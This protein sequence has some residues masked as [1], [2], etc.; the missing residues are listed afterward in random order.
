MPPGLYT[1]TYI[2]P[3][4]DLLIR[5]CDPTRD[6][7]RVAEL[8]NLFE[9]EKVTAERMRQLD[10]ERQPGDFFDRLV[11][12]LDGKIVATGWASR[13]LWYARGLYRVALL[14]D[15]ECHRLGYG[16]QLLAHLERAAIED[17]ATSLEASASDSDSGVGLAFLRRH[18]YEVVAHSFESTLDLSTFDPDRH[19]NAVPLQGLRFFSFAETPMDEDAKRRLWDLNTETS[20]DEPHNDRE[21]RPTFEQFEA[22]IIGAS[23]FDPHGQF[24][25]A[26]GDEW[27]AMSAVGEVY[28]GSLYNLFT[29]V[30]RAYCGRGIAKAV[31]VMATTFA[32]S[33]G[34]AYLRTNND[35][36]NAPML[37]IN[38]ALGYTSEPGKYQ[39]RKIVR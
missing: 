8:R 1:R 11:A 4:S 33:S 7:D 38:A 15:P 24:I 28:E 10:E 17:G 12:E 35:S 25:A 6:Y 19:R 13:N 14:V 16:S 22:S 3:S 29:G 5:S 21:H 23:W 27:I 18:G 34:K 20:R 36:R 2:M 26:D 32:K 31:K 39:A 37:A 30:R 9:P